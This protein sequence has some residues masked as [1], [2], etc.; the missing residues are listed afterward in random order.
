MIPWSYFN[1]SDISLKISW[2]LSNT[3]FFE[4]EILIRKRQNIW[5][6]FVD[7][8]RESNR[9][10]WEVVCRISDISPPVWS[11][12]SAANLVSL[13]PPAGCSPTSLHIIISTQLYSQ[14]PTKPFDE[15]QH[16]QARDQQPFIEHFHPNS[17]SRSQ[18]IKQ[19][20]L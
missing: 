8:S 2:S 16:S 6:M 18:T 13:P 17:Q 11:Q 10:N 12:T 5:R 19:M 14:P 9:D 15:S 1:L 20:K 7:L 4:T 3:I